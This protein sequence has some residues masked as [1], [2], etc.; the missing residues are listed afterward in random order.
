VDMNPE[1]IEICKQRFQYFPTTISYH[2]NDGRR[3]DML[4]PESADFIVCFDSMVHMHP[5]IIENYLVQMA[6]IIRP[7][8]VVWLDHSGKG[9]KSVGHR[10]DMT[11]VRMAEIA[12]TVGCHVLSQQFRNDWDCISV[13]QRPMR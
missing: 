12:A 11:A 9:A 1:G 3:L 2:V 7:G 6:E 8:G 4:E 5:E 13:I 10:T